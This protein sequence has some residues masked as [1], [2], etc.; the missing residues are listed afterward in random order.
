MIGTAA[1]SGFSNLKLMAGG[2][3]VGSTLATMPGN[4]V[5][6][7]DLSGSPLNIPT[8]QT[9]QLQLKADIM[10]EV[11]RNYQF[12]FLRNYD[13]IAYDTTYNVGVLSGSTFPLHSPTSAATINAG[14][15][16]I[17]RSATSRNTAVAGGLVP[18]YEL[19]INN[20][21]ISNLI[22]EARTHEIGTVV[23]TSSQDGMIDMDRSLAE[24]VRRGEVTV[25]D[26][27]ERASDQKTFERYL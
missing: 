1:A 13:I 22:R 2:V 23:Q 17:T 8:G 19:L 18:A 3:Q 21:A 15:L 27:Y 9:V 20:S 4:K 12:S 14:S 24:L 6:F 5:L 7:F 10:S 26:A 16:S 25:E 11:N